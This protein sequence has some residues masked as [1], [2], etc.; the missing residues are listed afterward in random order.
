[1]PTPKGHIALDLHNHEILV[2]RDIVFE[3]TIFPYPIISSKPSWEYMVP[4]TNIHSS[5]TAPKPTTNDHETTNDP[6]THQTNSPN[7]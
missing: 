3:E 5:S 6:S 2:S 1:M 7:F 4:P